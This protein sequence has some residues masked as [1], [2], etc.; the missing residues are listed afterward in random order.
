MKQDK[1]KKDPNSSILTENS[2]D[3]AVIFGTQSPSKLTPG[4]FPLTK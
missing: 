4:S 2:V 1:I 3:D